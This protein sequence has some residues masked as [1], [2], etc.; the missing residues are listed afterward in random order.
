MSMNLPRSGSG[1]LGTTDSSRITAPRLVA[2][3]RP[4]VLQDRRCPRVIPIVND[5]L[6]DVGIAAGRHS[7]EEVAFHGLATI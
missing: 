5:M 2:H 4:N 7:L 1:P 6:H 3:R